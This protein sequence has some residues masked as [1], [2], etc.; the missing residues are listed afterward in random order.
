MRKTL[1]VAGLTS[2]AGLIAAAPAAAAPDTTVSC[3]PMPLC[4]VTN[5]VDQFTGSVTDF[6]TNG[7]ETFQDSI[8]TGPKTFQGS[9]NDFV[10]NGPKEFGNSI[11][12]PGGEAPTP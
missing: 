10:T 12:N 6:V 9:V 4:V 2:A 8:V 3:S 7:P 1:V 11:T 5:N